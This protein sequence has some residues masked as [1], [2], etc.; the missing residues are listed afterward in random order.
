MRV[1]EKY[2]KSGYGLDFGFG[3]YLVVIVCLHSMGSGLVGK[4]NQ[5]RS[6]YLM[7]E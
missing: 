5:F 3:N 7:F 1:P 4:S 6:F 2:E